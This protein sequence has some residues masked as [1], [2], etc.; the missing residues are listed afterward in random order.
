M[1]RSF[2]SVTPW[3]SLHNED[4]ETIL[5][6]GSDN[7]F[8][9]HTRD[10][11]PAPGRNKS[12]NLLKDF[13]FDM[14]GQSLGVPSR[15]DFQRQTRPSSVKSQSSG[16][17]TAPVTPRRSREAQRLNNSNPVYAYEDTEPPANSCNMNSLRSCSTPAFNEMARYNHPNLPSQR[18]H[19]TYKMNAPFLTPQAFNLPPPPP[20]PPQP[21]AMNWQNHSMMNSM[22]HSG[23]IPT[24]MSYPDATSQFTHPPSYPYHNVTAFQGAP[25]WAT[26]QQDMAGQHPN[27]L[28]ISL[29]RTTATTI[30]PYYQQFIQARPPYPPQ[31]QTMLAPYPVNIPPPPPPPPPPQQ[32]WLQSY[33]IATG[34]S[35]V[36][37][38]HT[39]RP[40]N[41]DDAVKRATQIR[42]SSRNTRPTQVGGTDRAD[43]RHVTKHIRH[44]HV[45][46]GCGK[47][48]S[49]GYHRDNPLR[50]GEIPKLDYCRKCIEDAEYTD[51]G[52]SN[53]GIAGDA[54]FEKVHRQP[55][56][57][58]AI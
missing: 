9:T 4:G 3:P 47:K 34:R 8:I 28:G 48:R 44:V 18:Q 27:P 23:R 5:L 38:A 15:K 35:K 50:R 49:R 52:T 56:K 40:S 25:N 26:T 17:I 2:D 1:F 51:P 10:G 46:A 7:V 16:L 43:V 21:V 14:L 19:A 57:V 32:D 13:G 30:L 55:N 36:C 22:M 41:T 39:Q 42:N 6:P 33:A 58:K 24:S 29:P 31:V 53:A 11:K 12:D 45:C 54:S 20:P 37:T